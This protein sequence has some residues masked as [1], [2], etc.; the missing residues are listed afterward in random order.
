MTWKPIGPADKPIT[1]VLEEFLDAQR[2][3]LSPST[4]RKYQSVIALFQ[5]SMNGYGHQYLSKA[6]AA[7]FDDLYARKGGPHREF[8][9][10]FGAE[11]IPENVAEFLHYFMPHKVVCGKDLLRAAGTVTR[12]LGKW[13]CDE[14]YLRREEAADVESR[15]ARAAKDLPAAETLAQVLHAYTDRPA[16]S[17]DQ[18]LD[19]PFLMQAVGPDWLTLSSLIEC[20]EVTVPVPPEAARLCR[21][22]WTLSGRVGKTPR[23]WRLLDVYGAYS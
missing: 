14:G 15:G 8:C 20:G 6:E 12:R 13:L 23:G 11:K 1:A 19:G 18:E 3:R 4:A 7:L 17:H 21:E 2:R 10:V 5:R 16:P 9:D 22:G